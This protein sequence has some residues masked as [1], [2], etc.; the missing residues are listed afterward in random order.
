MTLLACLAQSRA[1]LA[2]SQTMHQPC[3]LTPHAPPAPLLAPKH[4]QGGGE[5]HV[6]VWGQPG[7]WGG[8]LGLAGGGPKVGRV[9]GV[10]PPPRGPEPSRAPQGVGGPDLVDNTAN[11]AGKGRSVG[12]GPAHYLRQNSPLPSPPPPR[13]TRAPDRLTPT[14]CIPLDTSSQEL[15]GG[16]RTVDRGGRAEE[17]HRFEAAALQPLLHPSHPPGG[18]PSCRPS[19]RPNGA[20]LGDIRIYASIASCLC[21]QSHRAL[22]R[23]GAARLPSSERPAC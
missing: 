1:T 18:N 23:L 16:A 4:A 12:V 7:G 20:W 10:P 19:R 3:H 15:H 6:G 8:S 9:V 11:S 2:A 14:S 13:A 5:G 21:H 17:L 22:A